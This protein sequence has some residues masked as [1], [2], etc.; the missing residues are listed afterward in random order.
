MRKFIGRQD[1]VI[2]VPARYW[3]DE[4]S[5]TTNFSGREF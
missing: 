3:L 5:L 2:G 4:A 1:D